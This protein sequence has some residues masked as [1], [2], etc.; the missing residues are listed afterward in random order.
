MTSF[1]TFIFSLNIPFR[2]IIILTTTLFEYYSVIYPVSI[3]LQPIKSDV[4]ETPTVCLAYQI[5]TNALSQTCYVQSAKFTDHTQ[6]STP[7]EWTRPYRARES[8]K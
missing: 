8:N 2:S 3:T 5:I 1:R 4:H 6:F 7:D